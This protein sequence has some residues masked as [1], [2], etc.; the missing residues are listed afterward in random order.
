MRP[1]DHDECQSNIVYDAIVMDAN[2]NT[3]FIKGQLVLT[4][5]RNL[6]GK[7]RRRVRDCWPSVQTPVDA[8]YLNHQRNVV[9]FKGSK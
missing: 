6:R 4:L 7:T 9:I 5:D 1:E 8:A 3:H 2:D